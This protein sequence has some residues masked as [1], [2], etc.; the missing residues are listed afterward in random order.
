MSSPRPQH[1]S[2][3][4][5]NF[6][7]TAAAYSSSLSIIVLVVTATMPLCIVQARRATVSVVLYDLVTRANGSRSGLSAQL[8]AGQIVVGMLQVH[9]VLDL[10]EQGDISCGAQR[11]LDA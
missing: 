8:T 3:S 6:T 10:V 9:V 7:S 2:Y 11:R 4:P 1:P 5:V